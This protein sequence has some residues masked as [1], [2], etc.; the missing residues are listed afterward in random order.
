MI[1]L[2]SRVVTPSGDS[3]SGN[4][5]TSD[6]LTSSS[7]S[8]FSNRLYF[9][10]VGQRPT[11]ST[12]F[13]SKGRLLAS[14]SVERLNR[15]E[16][17]PPS[18]FRGG[19]SWD[20]RSSSPMRRVKPSPHRNPSVDRLRRLDH[21]SSYRSISRDELNSIDSTVTS[22]ATGLSNLHPPSSSTMER[23]NM[24]LSNFHRNL[25][26]TGLS[27]TSS[28]FI[29]HHSHHGHHGNHPNLHPRSNFAASR[30]NLT[31]S[32]ASPSISTRSHWPTSGL[33][34]FRPRIRDRPSLASI[35]TTLKGKQLIKP[36][37]GSSSSRY[38][39]PTP[40]TSLSTTTSSPSD[41]TLSRYRH[42]IKFREFHIDEPLTKRKA[43]ISWD[44]PLEPISSSSS[45]NS[46]S[47]GN[48]QNSPHSPTSRQSTPEIDQRKTPDD[49]KSKLSSSS[50]SSSPSQPL[51]ER[52]NSVSRSLDD[53]SCKLK[54]P[55]LEITPDSLS[56]QLSS[57]DVIE[58][59]KPL[60]K[61]RT[62]PPSDKDR[63][64][65]SRPLAGKQN[66]HRKPSSPDPTRSS[67]VDSPI[68]SRPPSPSPTFISTIEEKSRKILSKSK[69]GS[70]SPN[71]TGSIT[72]LNTTN[73]KLQPNELK[74]NNSSSQASSSPSSTTSSVRSVVSPRQE[75]KLSKGI[76][77]SSSSGVNLSSNNSS[78][79]KL[80]PSSSVTGTT[81][82]T[83]TS[84]STSTSTSTTKTPISCH[85]SSQV[86]FPCE[87]EAKSK[88]LI[89]K[90]SKETEETKKRSLTPNQPN[91][92]SSS[93]NL[94]LA[95]SSSPSTPPPQS[96]PQT[97]NQV[98]SVGSDSSKV[99]PTHKKM[100]PP[101]TPPVTCRSS[102]MVKTSTDEVKLSLNLPIA[103]KSSSISPKSTS[104]VNMNPTINSKLT[105]NQVN[106]KSTSCPPTP[107][108][109]L[110]SYVVKVKTSSTGPK[111]MT[112]DK[113]SI[114]PKSN[115]I[116]STTIKGSTDK[117]NSIA[118][119]SL[120]SSDHLPGSP[121]SSTVN[122]VKLV[123]KSST[124]SAQSTIKQQSSGSRSPSINLIE[125]KMDPKSSKKSTTCELDKSN[126][127][128]SQSK[129]NNQEATIKEAEKLNKSINKINEKVKIVEQLKSTIESVDKSR[130]EV[131][132]DKLM[133]M[134]KKLS[135]KGKP[136]DS[137]VK[138]ETIKQQ[139]NGTINN[140]DSKPDK[141]QINQQ[142]ATKNDADRITKLLVN[143]GNSEEPSLIEDQKKERKRIRFRTYT[144]DD[145]ELRKVLGRGSFGK[146]YLAQLKDH[147]DVFFAIKFLKKHVVI[148]DDDLESIMVERKVLALGV[149]HPFICKLFCTFQTRGMV[150]FVME[151]LAGGDLMFHV[152]SCGRF[153]E[154][155]A[156]FY[157][158][159]I[160]SAL[161]FLH[162]RYI[163]YR[164]LKLDNILLDSEGH[165]RL[166]DFGMCQCHIW[167]EECLPS[168]FCGTPEYM[169]PEI[170]KGVQYNQAVDWWSFGVLLYEM[171]VGD[172][173]FKATDED[174]LLWNVC[175]EKVRIPLFVSS[176]AQ[177]IILNLLEHDPAE[178]LGMPT[179]SKGDIRSQKFFET[180]NW[181]AIN[182]GKIKPPFL[183]TLK[184]SSDTCYFDREFTEMRPVL[185]PIDDYTVESVDH[186]LFF[187]FDYT[188]PNMTD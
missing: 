56:G 166:V 26:P 5:F 133:K 99:E 177:S 76:T 137:K 128:K 43:S 102:P 88:G 94:P 125:K 96:Q 51:I 67:P 98:N 49:N 40:S 153:P 34:F 172:S 65:T 1:T 140:Q 70:T 180:I 141:N 15:S 142:N 176:N 183:P 29:G 64:P 14:S 173:P 138:D 174:E 111:G 50:S 54:I 100:S 38:I 112:G 109:T 167:K 35:K 170:I 78:P 129:E 127:S 144:M 18:A 136:E 6:Y 82:T 16:S 126:Q 22:G 89:L 53:R 37:S 11:S 39:R 61:G 187:G 139:L 95:S 159:E 45:Y 81:T 158:A 2:K 91:N 143:G 9:T 71:L 103:S 132:V 24:I 79:S 110:P 7:S 58:L 80:S 55:K 30:S 118:N 171:I 25:P 117:V 134:S 85:S 116:K 66:Y 36:S 106:S 147:H 169:A 151:F 160:V 86:T 107:T 184:H 69:S 31:T 149:K 20:L 42:V 163:I 157:A 52:K 44:L 182:S 179:S 181:D 75:L 93:P 152:Q 119:E 83:T 72:N 8:P 165:I 185:T 105:K 62:K 46:K 161:N 186:E 148:E 10:G 87:T 164:D 175:Y 74:I 90:I 113:Q 108:E 28:T 154:D 3:G 131:K 115:K 60:P 101:S 59:P 21:H 13:Y 77:N 145:F 130:D 4:K 17:P 135:V 63:P 33:E 124:D 104:P 19:S 178:R 123:K 97:L 73:S 27:S 122:P 23:R 47:S 168:N 155:R 57:P 12:S 120:I 68:S 114:L 121:S 41:A 48:S 146:V 150:C 162:S 84:P 92:R 156:R 32:S 188:N